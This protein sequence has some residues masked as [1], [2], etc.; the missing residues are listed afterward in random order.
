MQDQS[1]VTSN[2]MLADEFA[3]LKALAGHARIDGKRVGVIG[4]SKGGSAA[5]ARGA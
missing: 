1:T 2:D 4:F 3:A 5:S